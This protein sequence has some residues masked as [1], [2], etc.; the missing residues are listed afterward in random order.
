LDSCPVCVEI[1]MKGDRHASCD[2]RPSKQLHLAPRAHR[3]SMPH[4]DAVLLRPRAQRGTARQLLYCAA[5]VSLCAT[6]TIVRMP[7][8]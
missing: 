5:C 1:R 2:C 4:D 7:D 6:D 8:H 3:Q